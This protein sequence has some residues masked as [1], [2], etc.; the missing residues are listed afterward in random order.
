MT[1]SDQ[2]TLYI[3]EWPAKNNLWCLSST[4]DDH[5]FPTLDGQSRWSFIL[6]AK[7]SALSALQPY[8]NTI[9]EQITKHRYCLLNAQ[10][11]AVADW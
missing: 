1:Q 9:R 4:P 11:P 3:Y 10:L 6:K 2:L 7:L 8:A 5:L